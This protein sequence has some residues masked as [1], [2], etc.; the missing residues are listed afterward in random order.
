MFS[1]RDRTPNLFEFSAVPLLPAVN[2]FLPSHLACS[3]CRWRAYK[4]ASGDADSR[5]GRAVFLLDVLSILLLLAC[6]TVA[7]LLADA[8]WPPVQRHPPPGLGPIARDWLRLQLWRASG[9]TGAFLVP[10]IQR[11]KQQECF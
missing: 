4:V 3:A 5:C 11:R 7:S 8:D 2:S 10:A 1:F 9:S 6:F